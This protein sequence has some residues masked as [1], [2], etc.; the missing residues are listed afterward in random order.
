ML[1]HAALAM[2]QSVRHLAMCAVGKKFLNLS[3][4]GAVDIGGTN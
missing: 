2:E 1:P 3:S 4:Y